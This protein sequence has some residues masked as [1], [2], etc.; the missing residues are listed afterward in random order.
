M[1]VTMSGGTGVAMR[2]DGDVI[3]GG[4]GGDVTLGGV[5]VTLGG[6][7]IGVTMG[8][9]GGV[10]IQIGGENVIIGLGGVVIQG[11]GEGV[12]I[13]SGGGGDVEFGGRGVTFCGEFAVGRT[14]QGGSAVGFR[15]SA[16]LFRSGAAFC[17][18]FLA[19]ELH[20]GLVF[21][22]ERFLGSGFRRRSSHRAQ[23]FGS[24]AAYLWSAD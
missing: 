3:Q 4:G 22:A 17:I 1:G 6:G 11:D 8:G 12:V 16:V 24:G 19:A 13:H 5:D 10:V 14:L 15:G 18:R 23:V 21:G 7:G 2:G 20:S 9:G